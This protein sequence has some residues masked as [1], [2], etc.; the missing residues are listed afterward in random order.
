MVTFYGSVKSFMKTI[1]D[2]E[3]M[4]FDKNIIHLTDL[5]KILSHFVLLK[6]F[7]LLQALQ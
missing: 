7:L 2:Y 1:W 5:D 6:R 4:F 3:I